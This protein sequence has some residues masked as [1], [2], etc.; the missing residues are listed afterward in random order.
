[1]A[2]RKRRREETPSEKDAGAYGLIF[3]TFRSELDEHHDRRD[4]VLKASKDITASSKKM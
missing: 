3:L 4:R 1:M 2:D